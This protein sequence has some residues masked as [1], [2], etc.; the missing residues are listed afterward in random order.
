VRRGASDGETVEAPGR[1]DR[2]VA[3]ARR[4]RRICSHAAVTEPRPITLG[5]GDR[6]DVWTAAGGWYGSTLVAR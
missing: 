2:P 4:V 6:S 3:M 5:E 1:G